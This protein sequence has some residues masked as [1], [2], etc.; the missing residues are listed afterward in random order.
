MPTPHISVLMPVYNGQ[1]YLSLAVESILN[2]TFDNFELIV[3]DDGSTDRSNQVIRAYREKDSR[4]VLI[5]QSNQGI[6]AALNKALHAAKGKFCARMDADDISLPTRFLAQVQFL[7]RHLDVVV[8]GGQGYII[9]DDGDPVCPL[10]VALSDDDINAAL[11]RVHG[12]NGYIHPSVMFR[13]DVAKMIGGYRSQFIYAEDL[14]FFLRMG[15]S[16]KLANLDKVVLYYRQ[17][18]KSISDI[19]SAQQQ[20]S[21]YDAIVEARQR[22]NMLPA[23]E[24]LIRLAPTKPISALDYS[25]NIAC[26]A[27][28]NGNRRTSIKH[29]KKI[30]SWSKL[31]IPGWKIILLM[32]MPTIFVNILGSIKHIARVKN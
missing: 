23:S 11:L 19:K 1:E 29:L 13:T 3:V 4:V 6:V 9:D 5:E 22:R 28:R 10:R 32:V 15:E 31:W 30:S 21:A 16:G 24:H 20:D 7:E 12:C 25:I 14:D 18:G 17:H 26:A 8:V 2:Q 27:E